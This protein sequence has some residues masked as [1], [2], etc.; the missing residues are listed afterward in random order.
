LGAGPE[1]EVH[2][3]VN[4]NRD[5]WQTLNFN[6][7]LKLNFN[8]NLNLKLPLPVALNRHVQT[9]QPELEVKVDATGSGT[10][11]KDASALQ[12]STSISTVTGKPRGLPTRTPTYYSVS[13]ALPSGTLPVAHNLKNNFNVKLNGQY[14]LPGLRSTSNL[15]PLTKSDTESCQWCQ[16]AGPLTF[17]QATRVARQPQAD[18]CPVP[19]GLHKRQPRDPL[20]REVPGVLRLHGRDHLQR[21]SGSGGE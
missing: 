19:V 17:T 2:G 13:S 4:L 12:S 10:G 20:V 5:A 15:K 11:S 21:G 8:F 16:C 18:P 9:L 3:S 6:M 14:G 7:K 1:L